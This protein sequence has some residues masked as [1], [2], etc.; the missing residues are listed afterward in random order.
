MRRQ[1]EMEDEGSKI[2]DTQT[3]KALQKLQIDPEN[4]QT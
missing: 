3:Q 2:W 1:K 4:K